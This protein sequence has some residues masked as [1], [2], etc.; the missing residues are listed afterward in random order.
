MDCHNR[1]AHKFLSPDDAVNLYLETGRIER[2]L[3]FIKREAMAVLSAHYS[4]R[5][6]ADAEIQRVIT[7]YYRSQHPDVWQTSEASVNRAV[8]DIQAIY[9]ENFFP[10][11]KVNWETY[12]DNIGHFHSPGCFRCHDGKHVNQKGEAICHDCDVCHTFLNAVQHDEREVISE[13]QFIHPFELEGLHAALRCDECHGGGSSPDP[14]CAGC[15][16][17]EADFRRGVL[18]GIG[19]LKLPAEPMADSVDCTDC[20]DLSKP[21]TLAA[22]D[23]LC[24]DCHDDDP[25]RYQGLLASWKKEVD[26][27]L[28]HISGSDLSPNQR[29]ML[30]QLREAGPLHNMEATRQVIK[31]MTGP[32]A[33]V[34]EAPR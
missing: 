21:R 18:A 30:K 17:L 10:L 5:E 3:P 15:H 1:P 29:A 9:S 11:M 16:A 24:M 34:A 8:D 33:A 13:G 28:A 7:Q 20:H 12:P 6:H 14:T 27:N 32:G 26:G 25:E 2:G 4:S 31:S 23:A 19:D 22:I